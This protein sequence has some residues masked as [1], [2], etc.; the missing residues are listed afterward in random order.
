M[1]YQQFILE[2]QEKVNALL[3]KDILATI[4]HAQKN[5]GK[6]RVGLTISNYNT[7]IS[8]TIYLEEYFSQYQFSL[9][10]FRC[11]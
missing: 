10:C 5:N 3:D 2:I 8:P 7:N 1:N 11:M 9:R 6:V 4:H